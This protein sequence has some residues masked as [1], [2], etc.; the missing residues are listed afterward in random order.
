M[1]M[2]DNYEK[3]LSLLA[4]LEIEYE[5]GT[6]QEVC[7]D[8]SWKVSNAEIQFADILRKLTGIW[9]R[10]NKG[11][12]MKIIFQPATVYHFVYACVIGQQPGWPLHG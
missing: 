7:T 2:Y 8:K 1:D 5:D 3:S 9:S 10:R 4:Q 12:L 11:C 6:K